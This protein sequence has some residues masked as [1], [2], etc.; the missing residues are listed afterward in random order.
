MLGLMQKKFLDQPLKNDKITYGN[1]IN[2]TTGQGD[3]YKTC[4]L[5]DYANFR[6]NY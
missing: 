4:F 2:I 1:I 5:L 6:D 3:D